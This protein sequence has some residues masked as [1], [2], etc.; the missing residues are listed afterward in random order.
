MW[1]PVCND[2]GVVDESLIRLAQEQAELIDRHHQELTN[3]TP[4][5]ET[6]LTTSFRAKPKDIPKLYFNDLQGAEADSLLN[7][8]F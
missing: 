2:S 6:P 5:R 3:S 1:N 8:F 4:S 7:L